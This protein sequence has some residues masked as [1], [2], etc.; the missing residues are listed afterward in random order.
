MRL[1]GYF[2]TG[3]DTAVGKTV[4]TVAWA[5]ALA[6]RGRRVLACK[7]LESGGDE[8]ARRIAEA[9]GH[10]PVCLY[11][12]APPLA[13]GIA[14][15]ESGIEIDFAR[16]DETIREAAR[17]RSAELVL[18]EGA[19]GIL[20]PLGG[21]RT[22]AELAA[23]LGLPVLVVARSGLGTINHTVLT[24]REARRRG[25]AVAGVLLNQV[26]AERTPDERTNAALIERLGEVRVLGVLGHASEDLPVSLLAL[27]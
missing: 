11:R 18:V 21:H 3:T 20:C 27:G 13:P 8:D 22:M 23:Q 6:R 7:P 15:E 12:F 25:L 2:I 14:A 5:R 26:T 17:A 9:A 16:I 19:G 24:V 10:A 4:V 1:A